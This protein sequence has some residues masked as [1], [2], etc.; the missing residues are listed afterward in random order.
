MKRLFLLTFLICLSSL[1]KA[2]QPTFADIRWGASHDEVRK[3]LISKGFS[4]GALDKDGDFKFEG[5][6]VGHKA[7]GL[8]LFGDRKVA[9]VI[10]R[11][12]TP[13]HKAIETYRSMKEVLT[14]KYGKPS[15]DYEF[16]KKPYYDGDGFEAQ[17][18]KLG[19]A[20]FSSFWGSALN[21]EIH[22]SLTVQL[23]YESDVWEKEYEKRKAR[24]NSV[25]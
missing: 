8:A 11:I 14:K 7:Q 13:D 19:K 9:K 10:V 3:Q 20:T 12:I 22:E 5:S 17:A 21:L 16:F 4:P 6:L 1:V 23:N 24:S 25:F 18:I 2:E 15:S